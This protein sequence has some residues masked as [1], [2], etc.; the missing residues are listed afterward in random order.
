MKA[1]LFALL[2]LPALA[3]AKEPGPQDFAST[4]SLGTSGAGAFHEL[5]LPASVLES[6]TRR[7]FG[8]LRV[9]DAQDRAVPHAWRPERPPETLAPR[10]LPLPIFPLPARALAREAALAI[11]MVSGETRV[12]IRG[13]TPA[14]KGEEVSGYL[15][16]ARRIKEPLAALVLEWQNPRLYQGRV[17]LEASEDLANWVS[18]AQA[19]VILRSDFQGQTLSRQRVEWVPR[20]VKFLRL[21]WPAGE[22]R[23]LLEAAMGETA[24]LRGQQQ[25]AWRRARFV[26][27]GEKPGEYLY[28][29]PEAL[30]VDRLRLAYPA[31]NTMLPGDILVRDGDDAPWA[32]VAHSVFYRVEQPGGTLQS[33]DL[34]IARTQRRGWLLRID[35][36]VAVSAPPDL[37]LGWLPP[38]LVFLAQGEAPFQLAYGARK[39]P[40]AALPIA[41]LVPDWER[42]QDEA[43]STA[44]PGLTRPA[45]GEAMRT[46]SFDWKRL[47]LWGVLGAGV[48]LLAWLAWGLVRE[49]AKKQ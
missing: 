29:S 19:A 49:T 34:V 15:L 13:G 16:D 45:G 7:D 42:R 11:E 14:A 48:L 30:P 32:G 25:R 12:N 1:L 26:A 27:A 37:E 41:T 44:L 6:L 43:M 3:L 40:G 10:R 17:N 8:D 33:P 2:C 4:L 20:E 36:R 46:Q 47:A 24:A 9:F 35:P 23:F 5:M 22:T 39:V 21:T 28:E 31:G 18:L 38:R